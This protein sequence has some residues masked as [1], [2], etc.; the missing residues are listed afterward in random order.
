MKRREFLAAG[1][2][3]AALTSA[4][5]TSGKAS[6]PMVRD[7]RYKDQPSVVLESEAMRVEFVTQGGRM[8]SLREKA[9]DKEFAGWLGGAWVLPERVANI[10]PQAIAAASANP[11][12][13]DRLNDA[14]PCAPA[15]RFC[16]SDRRKCL[17]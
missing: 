17:R 9:T 11:K 8:V 14:D 6:M 1:S 16:R 5:F 7:S 12:A 10:A 2:T 3:V 13:A 15:Q 4:K